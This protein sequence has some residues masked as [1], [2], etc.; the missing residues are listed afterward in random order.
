[1]AT[2]SFP[3]FFKSKMQSH[4]GP[5]CKLKTHSPSVPVIILSTQALFIMNFYLTPIISRV[6]IIIITALLQLRTLWHK[7]FGQLVNFGHTMGK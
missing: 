2:V 3:T 7:E 1:M 6:A 5:D 4:T